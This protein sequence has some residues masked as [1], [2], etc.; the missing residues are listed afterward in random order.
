MVYKI[1]WLILLLSATSFFILIQPH[2]RIILLPKRSNGTLQPQILNHDLLN[3]IPPII[4]LHLTH[5]NN[6]FLNIVHS[7]TLI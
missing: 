4:F 1:L 5:L 2:H 3:N 6:I 7:L